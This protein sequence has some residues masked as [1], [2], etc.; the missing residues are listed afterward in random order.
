MIDFHPLF[1]FSRANCIAICG[2]LVP[3]NLL[4]TLQTMILTGLGRPQRKVWVSAGIASICAL[5]M[6]LHVFTWFA[7]GVVMAPTYI[8]L[9]LGTTCLAIN[10]CCVVYPLSTQRFFRALYSFA[11]G[12]LRQVTAKQFKLL[13]FK[14]QNDET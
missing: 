1:E 9:C 10:F 7:I 6:V 2:F 3:A 11:S 4:T 13:A 8:L 12:T 5:V 14:M